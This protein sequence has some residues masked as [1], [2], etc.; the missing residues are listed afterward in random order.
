VKRAFFLSLV[1]LAVA[2]PVAGAQR[3]INARLDGVSDGSIVSGSVN[4][5]G[6]ASSPA[7]IRRITLTVDGETVAELTPSGVRQEAEVTFDWDTNY[8][9]G[10]S[11]LSRNREYTVRVKAVSNAGAEEQ[12]SA[13][14]IVDNPPAVPTD[15]IAGA[16]K[17]DVMLSWEPNPE[18][19]I[20]GYRIERFFGNEYVEAAL[21]EETEFSEAQEPGRYSYRVVAIRSSQVS[22]EGL[23]SE[24]SASV[25]VSVEGSGRGARRAGSA[26][27]AAR[28]KVAGT[29]RGAVGGVL[30][31]RGLPRG[32]ALPGDAGLPPA[33]APPGLDWG[34]FEK[35]LPYR[36]PKGGV[37]I[38]AAQA[39]KELLGAI[40]VIPP[41]G[42]RWV[43]AG[44][45]LMVIAALL[46]YLAWH[47]GAKLAT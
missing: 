36:L 27:G 8:Y 32:V 21:V 40:R 13:T 38:K 39:D 6:R 30:G 9:V 16:K 35:R 10:S 33:P 44:M 25:T 37:P 29:K 4:L 12:A 47:A 17:D 2:V 46:R 18:P 26:A 45:L 19:D 11:Q 1:M 34:S 42:L 20:V 3:A 5:V 28:G 43:A 15:L 23:A 31:S 41:D 24:P 14:V 7:G 22:S